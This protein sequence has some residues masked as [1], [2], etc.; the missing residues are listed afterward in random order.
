MHDLPAAVAVV[1]HAGD[2]SASSVHRHGD[3]VDDQVG[4][5]V[6][7]HRPAPTLFDHPEYGLTPV[8]FVDDEPLVPASER[9]I[10]V[11][12]GTENFTRLLLED[13]IRNVI[14]A[15]MSSRE[16]VMVDMLR[17]CDRLKCDIFFVPRLYEL[18][19]QGRETEL[20]WDSRSPGSA[21]PPTGPSPGG[22]NGSSTSSSPASGWSC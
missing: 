4:L 19:G 22:P 12:R 3:R 13:R 15:F 7:G 10:P 20:I 9:H 14:V 6:A 8:G 1:D 21:G 2:M 16:S 17:T 5:A 18:H 11:L